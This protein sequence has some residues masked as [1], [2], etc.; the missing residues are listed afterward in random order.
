MKHSIVTLS[1]FLSIAI[2]SA[3]PQGYAALAGVWNLARDGADV[4]ERTLL[5]DESG[6][7]RLVKKNAIYFR[8]EREKLISTDGASFLIMAQDEKEYGM[9]FHISGIGYC[10]TAEAGIRVVSK[11]KDRVHIE[12]DEFTGSYPPIFEPSGMKYGAGNEYVRSPP[13]AEYEVPVRDERVTACASIEKREQTE[14]LTVSAKKVLVV[15]KYSG[16][17]GDEAWYRIKFGNALKWIKDIDVPKGLDDA[18]PV[19]GF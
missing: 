4:S 18:L 15:A 2:S 19:I 10:F 9:Y 17:T 12:K 13:L 16:N 1:V 3:Y 5:L 8:P 7:T 11:G 14:T 6:Q